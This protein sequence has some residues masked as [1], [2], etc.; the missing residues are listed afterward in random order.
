VPILS[1]TILVTTILAIAG[2]LKGFDLIFALTA[3]GLMRNNAMVLPIHMYQTAFED[4]TNPM[5]FAYGASISNAIVLI[6]V[7]LILFSNW[8]ARR[9]N[10]EGAS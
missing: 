4:Y 7:V 2:S 8:V 5:R 3:K 10:A 9:F 6:S 1:G